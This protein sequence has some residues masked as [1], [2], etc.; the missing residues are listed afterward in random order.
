MDYTPINEYIN[1]L[2]SQFQYDW[3]IFSTPWVM[4]TVL[5]AIAYL[6]FFV[7]KWYILLAPITVPISVFRMSS[8]D[9]NAS[10]IKDELR[11]K[12]K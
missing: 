5:P 1:F 3:S 7:C 10:D 9:D 6:I 11:S 4:Y 8:N 2:W 12:L